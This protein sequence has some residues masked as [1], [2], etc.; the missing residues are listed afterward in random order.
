MALHNAAGTAQVI[1]DVAGWF[2]DGTSPTGGLF[3]P[4]SPSRILD[5]RS[6][7][8]PLGSVAGLDV[9]VTGRGGVPAAG[10]SAV[11]MNVAVTE[12]T[13]VSYLT[14]FPSGEA[15]PWAANLNYVPN[16]TVPNL[17]VAKLGAGGRASIANAAGSTQ[18]I[19]DVAGWFDAG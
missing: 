13:A 16:Q 6:G 9:Q 7:G 5:T 1:A 3:H 17:V 2:D 19:A 18:V 8:G 11:V 4:V 10:V 15:K 14:V 12:P